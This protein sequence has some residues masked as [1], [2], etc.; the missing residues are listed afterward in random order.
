MQL[1]EVED[2]G[3]ALGLTHHQGARELSS[4]VGGAL[5]GLFK[6]NCILSLVMV[7][8]GGATAMARLLPAFGNPLEAP[9]PLIAGKFFGPFK[10]LATE[11]QPLLPQEVPICVKI[12]L[13]CGGI[14]FW[15][16]PGAGSAR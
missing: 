10:R 9:P 5:K 1:R 6:R 4:P 12:P 16:R 2:R 11:R 13:Q 15:Q 14:R 7:I 3:L 8:K